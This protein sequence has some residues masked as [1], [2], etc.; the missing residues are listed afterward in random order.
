MPSTEFH[1]CPGSFAWTIFQSWALSSDTPVPEGVHLLN[2][3]ICDSTLWAPERRCYVLKLSGNAHFSFGKRSLLPNPS[4]T[5]KFA[6]PKIVDTT[7]DMSGGLDSGRVCSTATLDI[8][9]KMAADIPTHSIFV[10]SS[11]CSNIGNLLYIGNNN[12]REKKN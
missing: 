1:S 11:H 8:W 5:V 6:L 9:Y 3:P 2:I 4:H 10:R 12:S 7:E